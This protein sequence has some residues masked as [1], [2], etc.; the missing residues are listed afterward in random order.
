MFF[1]NAY[2]QQAGESS[3][4]GLVN[5]LPILLIFVIFYFLLFRPQQ[6]KEKARQSMLNGLQR[7]D[8]IVTG[9]GLIG[10]IHRINDKELVLEVSEGVRINVLRS[11][12]ADVYSKEPMPAK[13]SETDKKAQTIP[14]KKGHK[15]IK[16][17]AAPV[18]KKPSV[19]SSVKK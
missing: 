14:Q 2:A 15:N 10:M 11:A 3:S 5:L 18:K 4:F 6:K 16:T 1:E 17:S 9:G 19:E 13:T 8:K 7:G 12:I